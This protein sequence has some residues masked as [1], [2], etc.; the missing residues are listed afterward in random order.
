MEIK[1][2]NKPKRLLTE[3]MLSTTIRNTITHIKLTKHKNI[4]AKLGNA[5][6]YQI[7]LQLIQYFRC[8]SYDLY[9]YIHLKSKHLPPQSGILYRLT[10]LIVILL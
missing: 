6:L 1:G 9:F 8:V 7:Q 10:H 5:R 2:L 3:D 4:Y